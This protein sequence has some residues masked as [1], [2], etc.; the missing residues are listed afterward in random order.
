MAE[1]RGVCVAAPDV[2]E[3]RGVELGGEGP[4]IAAPHEVGRNGGW[5]AAGSRE[6]TGV[7][8]ASYIRKARK[9]FLSRCRW[10]D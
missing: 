2:A 5:T 9:P 4:L 1:R 7:T 3:R 10:S 6:Q 8:A